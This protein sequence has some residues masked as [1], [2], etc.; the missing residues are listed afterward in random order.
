MRFAVFTVGLPEYTLEESVVF[1][2]D[3]G[4]DGVE[5]RVR[6]QAYSPDG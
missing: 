5:W 6:Y 4:Y 1:L 2:R 3:L